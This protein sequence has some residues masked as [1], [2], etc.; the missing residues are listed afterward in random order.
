[1]TETLGTVCAQIAAGREIRNVTLGMVAGRL[2]HDPCPPGQIC[3]MTPPAV[4]FRSDGLHNKYPGLNFARVYAQISFR[5]C[6]ACQSPTAP[7]SGLQE[8]AVTLTMEAEMTALRAELQ[9]LRAENSALKAAQSKHRL[10]APDTDT[11]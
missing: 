2:V 10:G 8:S 5:A 11:Y 4:P 7:R 6:P 1:M 3:V 9:R